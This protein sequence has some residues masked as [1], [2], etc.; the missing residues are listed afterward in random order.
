MSLISD[1]QKDLLY[2]SLPFSKIEKYSVGVSSK[3]K[4]SKMAGKFLSLLLQCSS[5][6]SMMISPSC[7][8]YQ[9]AHSN[10][11]HKC[12]SLSSPSLTSFV[13][14]ALVVSSMCSLGADENE[15]SSKYLKFSPLLFFLSETLFLVSPKSVQSSELHKISH[16]HSRYTVK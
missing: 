11:T 9:G 14:G 13:S 3:S 1:L 6:A 5:K 8:Y 15:P 2:A 16:L 10:S 7:I 12:N 4:Y